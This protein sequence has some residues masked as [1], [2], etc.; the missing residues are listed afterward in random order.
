MPRGRLPKPDAVK[1]AAGNPGK[2]KIPALVKPSAAR[3]ATSAFAPPAW[4]DAAAR[5][6]WTTLAADLVRL[7]F[8]RGS[9]V[10][11]FA[12]YCHHMAG[13]VKARKT[14]QKEG[15]FYDATATSGEKLKRLHP[16]AK[17]AELHEK[18]LVELEDR[19]GLTP[20]ARQRILR[21]Q[22]ALPAGSLPFD[23]QPTEPK[24]ADDSNPVKPEPAPVGSPVSLLSR[25]H[26]PLQ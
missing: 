26:G 5:R 25:P 4:L 21:D 18:H 22:A 6:I 2:R 13:W 15:E 11:A 17:A 1:R 7:N 24:P 16:A 20:L 23:R 10:Q 19:F 8:L 3:A 9:D 14:V 12:R